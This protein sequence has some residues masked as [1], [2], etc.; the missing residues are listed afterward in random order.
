MN[1]F[2]ILVSLLLFPG[3]A[4]ADLKSELPENLSPQQILSPSHSSVS[5]AENTNKK[6]PPAHASSKSLEN[7]NL[8]TQQNSPTSDFD[9]HNSNAPVFFSG[10]HG[11]GFR[12]TGTLNLVGDVV[13]VQDEVMLKSEK[14][15]IISLAGHLPSAGAGRIKS[16]IASGKVIITKKTTIHSPELKAN[17]DSAEFDV[18]QR[19]LTLSGNAKVWRSNEYINGEKIKININTGDIEIIHPMGTIDPQADNN[20]FTKKINN[21]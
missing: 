13:I 3:L 19:I 1:R 15:Q 14:A 16:A 7:K 18:P 17:C 11:E 5:E 10:N 21:K 20:N 2:F 4:Y 9:H 12:K 6:I 8:E